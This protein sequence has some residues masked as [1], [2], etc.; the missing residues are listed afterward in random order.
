MQK[1]NATQM[2]WAF[3]AQSIQTANVVQASTDYLNAVEDA[4]KQL[5]DSL[6]S[7]PYRNEAAPQ[8]QGYACYLQGLQGTA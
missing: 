2:G 3:A 5:E 4:I 7:H 1:S 6:N 8:F